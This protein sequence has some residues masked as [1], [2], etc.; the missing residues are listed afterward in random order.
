MFFM[1]VDLILSVCTTTKN[2]AYTYN[3]MLLSLT[4]E[5]DDSDTCCNMD[6]P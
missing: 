4:N 1:S 5:Y 6:D 2:V 3:V